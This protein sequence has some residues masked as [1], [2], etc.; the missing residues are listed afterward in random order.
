MT[1]YRAITGG[2]GVKPFRISIPT[3][4]LD[5]LRERL[6]RTRLAPA[7]SD[8]WTHGTPPAYLAELVEHWRTKFDWAQAERQLNQL[9][10]FT[11]PVQGSDLHFV[12]AEGV[13]PAPLPLLFSHGWPGSFWEVSKI[14][15]PLTAATPPTRSPSSRRAC[16]A[17]ASPRIPA[18][19]A[20]ARPSSP[21]AS[22][23]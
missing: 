20:S 14:I 21:S 12:R 1:G 10:Q 15:G 4:D 11:A 22:T 13:G 16:P 8:D 23:R 2:T 3:R 17:T 19:P 9:P 6:A 18:P 5:D 7:L